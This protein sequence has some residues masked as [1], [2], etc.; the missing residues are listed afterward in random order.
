MTSLGLTTFTFPCCPLQVGR[1]YEAPYPKLVYADPQAYFA[2][3]YCY[4]WMQPIIS[5]F[6]RQELDDIYTQTLLLH[7]YI[8][9]K[10]RLDTLWPIKPDTGLSQPYLLA[11]RSPEVRRLMAK[12]HDKREYSFYRE[13]MNRGGEMAKKALANERD[14]LEKIV[15]D[16]KASLPRENSELDIEIEKLEMEVTEANAQN[17][18]M[19]QEYVVLS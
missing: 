17:S 14:H 7:Y 5:R 10:T 1:V 13:F 3:C 11:R 15:S 6:G 18:R 19:V 16:I 8:S 9:V 4:N 12:L 2:A